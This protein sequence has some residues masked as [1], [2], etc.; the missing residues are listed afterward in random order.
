MVL[1]GAPFP[2]LQQEI[3][4]ILAS[5]Y[6]YAGSR[7][8]ATYIVPTYIDPQCALLGVPKSWLMNTKE[9]PQ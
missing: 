6:A 1:V 8:I 7:L 9:N 5:L 4:I 2:E 3:T